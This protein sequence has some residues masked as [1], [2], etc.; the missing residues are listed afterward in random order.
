MI[1][2]DVMHPVVASEDLQVHRVISA[3]L[4]DAVV[5]LASS[6]DAVVCGICRLSRQSIYTLPY[7]LALFCVS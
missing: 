6:D 7:A 5:L 3:A 4:A 1:A 2:F